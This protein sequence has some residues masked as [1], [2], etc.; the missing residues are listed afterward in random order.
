MVLLNMFGVSM[1]AGCVTTD[2]V[3]LVEP[4]AA[5]YVNYSP[6][7]TGYSQGYD[8]YGNYNDGYGP[9]FWNPRTYFYTGYNH[10]Y[11]KNAYTT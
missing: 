11:A 4:G 5:R 8:G 1:L 6:G 3:V 10:G 9:S 7:F 2:E